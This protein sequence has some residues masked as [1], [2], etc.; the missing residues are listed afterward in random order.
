M[1]GPASTGY[2]RIVMAGLDPAIDHLRKTLLK[3]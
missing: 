1:N 2:H 3:I